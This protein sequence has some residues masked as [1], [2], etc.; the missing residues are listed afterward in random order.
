MSPPTLEIDLS[1]NSTTLSFLDTLI[2]R[3]TT[4]ASRNSTVFKLKK[5]KTLFINKAIRDYY[6]RKSLYPSLL[7][8]TN[9]GIE[10]SIGLD[11]PKDYLKGLESTLTIDELSTLKSYLV[12]LID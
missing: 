7:L 3:Y 5:I 9:K 1:T 12:I 2:D 4:L 8:Y 10:N 11:A 6:I